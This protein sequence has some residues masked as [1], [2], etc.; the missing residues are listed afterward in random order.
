MLMHKTGVRIPLTGLSQA[1]RKAKWAKPLARAHCEQS[2]IGN[3]HLLN[4]KQIYNLICLSKNE[5]LII[6]T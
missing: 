3:F 4:L 1:K 6:V 2:V 5:T